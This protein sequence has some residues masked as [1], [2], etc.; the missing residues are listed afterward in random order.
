MSTAFDRSAL[1]IPS[2]I[3]KIDAG[4]FNDNMN[5]KKEIVKTKVYTNNPEHPEAINAVDRKSVV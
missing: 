2:S 5:S 1:S 3:K 4:A